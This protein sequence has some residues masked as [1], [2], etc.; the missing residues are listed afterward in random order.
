MKISKQSIMT[1]VLNPKESMKHCGMVLFK[2]SRSGEEMRGDKWMSITISQALKTLHTTDLDTLKR[3]A[4]SC[5]GT[6]GLNLIKTIINS[7]NL[8]K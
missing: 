6:F 4:M 8:F 2:S 7:C 1:V 3:Y 5:C